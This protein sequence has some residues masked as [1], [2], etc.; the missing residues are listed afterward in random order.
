M[1]PFLIEVDI[2]WTS[3]CV[4][5]VILMQAGFICLESGQVRSVN[6]I[7][8]AIKNIVDFCI[9]ALVFWAI[10]YGLMFGF[11]KGGI[12]GSDRMFAEAALPA[13]QLFFLFQMMFCC[14]AVTIISGAIAERMKL[15]GYIMVAFITAGLIYPVTG[16]WSWSTEASGGGTG[17]LAEAGFFDYAGSTVVHSVGGWIALSSILIIGP[18]LGRFTRS[19]GRRKFSGTNLPIA[20]LGTILLFI[21]WL[22]FN[23]GNE[24]VVSDKIPRIFQSTIFAA[25]SGGLTACV[26]SWHLYGKPNTTMIING[27]LA[28]LVAITASCVVISITSVV[29]ISVVGA[30]ISVSLSLV[31]SKYHIDDVVGA[32]PVHLGPGIW[33][34]IAVALFADPSLWDGELDRWAQLKVQLLGIASIGLYAFG[35]SYLML[36]LINRRYALRVSPEREL[37]GLNLSELAAENEIIELVR[38]IDQQAF[39]GSFHQ[40]LEVDLA[41]ETAPVVSAYNR[42]VDKLNFKIVELTQ[43]KEKLRQQ[44]MVD[45]LT[46]LYNRRYFDSRYDDE[47]Q[48]SHREKTCLSIAMIDIDFF[49]CYNDSYGHQGGD[50]CLK[51][52]ADAISQS[53]LRPA[54]MAARYGG[55]EFV[56]LLPN[57]EGEG[58]CEVVDKLQAR[59]SVL[60][61]PH[62]A[63]PI[64][65]IVSISIGVACSTVHVSLSKEELLEMADQALYQAKQQGRNRVVMHG[66][67]RVELVSEEKS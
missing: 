11:S 7:S 22:G 19:D 54:D 52:V 37:E 67:S 33:G 48:R 10:G 32:V 12:I 6:S 8:V 60:G 38:D 63:S 23:G 44:A 25:A 18:R 1:H 66:W 30:L 43:L 17:W 56:L 55:E 40:H 65:K 14:T 58:A 42:T 29:L 2:A 47:W 36:S 53:I 4:T 51:Q 15:S 26:V 13:E 49:K 59:I 31:L 46:G 35:L 45:S 57:T 39:K 50:Q 61:I 20:A 62:R 27:L 34:T 41:S 16:H 5:L 9:A 28:G 64:D 3:T 21:G 24:Y